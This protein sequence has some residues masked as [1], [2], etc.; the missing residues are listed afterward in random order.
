MMRRVTHLGGARATLG[1][2]C[3]LLLWDRQLG[4]AALLANAGSHVVVQLL[5]ATMPPPNAPLHRILVV[6]DE[7]DITAL[8]A[9]I[10]R[11]RATASSRRPTARTRCKPP[12]KSVPISSSSISCFPMCRATTCSPS[13]DG[14]TRPAKSASSCSR[15]ATRK[16][17]GSAD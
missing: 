17:T 10:W 9:Y 8:V 16:W 11:R 13:C 3:A 12:G 1:A 14:A 2:G 6:D 7:P 5:H 15:L 4:A